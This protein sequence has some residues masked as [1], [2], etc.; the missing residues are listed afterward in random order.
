MHTVTTVDPIASVPV[1]YA[2]AML[3]RSSRALSILDGSL[4]YI[5][6]MKCALSKKSYN[7]F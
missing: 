1:A 7:S 3:D 4:R 5:N 6:Y 2:E